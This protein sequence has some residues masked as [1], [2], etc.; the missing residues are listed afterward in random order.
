MCQRPKNSS[1]LSVLTARLY[2]RHEKSGSKQ[3]VFP[4]RDEKVSLGLQ[5]SCITLQHFMH[6]S[7]VSSAV[8]YSLQYCIFCSVE[9]TAVLYALHCCVVCTA[10][11][12]LPS[13][14]ATTHHNIPHRNA[15]HRNAPHRNA[16]QCTAPRG[17]REHFSQ[18]RTPLKLSPKTIIVQSNSLEF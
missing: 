14:C 12:L 17:V 4:M 3:S 1:F 7:V 5:Q 11:N 18:G 15:P 6:Y 8:F 16:T 13:W 10:A 9:C 2:F